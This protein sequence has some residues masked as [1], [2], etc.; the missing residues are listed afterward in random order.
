[1]ANAKSSSLF[2]IMFPLLPVIF[3]DLS[4]FSLLF[5][6]GNTGFQIPQISS[7]CINYNTSLNNSWPL[8]MQ[9]KVPHFSSHLYERQMQA[10]HSSDLPAIYHVSLI[11]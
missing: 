3:Y 1:M 2:S 8:P 6:P 7:M 4:L 10:I 5:R 9:H 11:D